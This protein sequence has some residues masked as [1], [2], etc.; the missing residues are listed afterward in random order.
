M[1]TDATKKTVNERKFVTYLDF[2]AAGDGVTD[3]FAAI[4]KAHEYANEN[5]LPV[6]TDDGRTYYIHDT[7]IDGEVKSAIIRTDVNWGSSS[8][9]ID[10]TDIDY[11]D[12]TKRASTY[13]FNVASDYP[14]E[15]ITDR[16]FL[17]RLD[18]IGEGTAKLD[19]TLGYPAML[20]IYDENASVF[21]RC[22]SSY[23]GKGSPKKELIVIDG[24]GNVDSSTPFMFDY[25]TV[26]R[27]EIYRSDVKP[28]TIRGGKFTTRGCR[29]DAL[30]NE[31]G[32]KAGY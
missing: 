18:G 32:K 10:D 27:L 25:D 8:F 28:I 29:V 21:N 1:I 4:V 22:G 7:L 20:V 31:T 30:D 2:G 23:S 11:Y 12:G 14:K 19:L 3:D 24:D 6:I 16:E 13:I 17:S 15:V 5:C 9:I 26:T